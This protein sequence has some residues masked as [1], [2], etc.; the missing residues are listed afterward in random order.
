MQ[1]IEQDACIL[2]IRPTCVGMN[3]KFGELAGE[4]RSIRPTCVG[5]NLISAVMV[6]FLRPIRPTCVGMNRAGRRN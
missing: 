1:R 2:Y 5:M 3:R 6:W 4:G